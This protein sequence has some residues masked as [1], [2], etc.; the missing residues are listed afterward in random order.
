MSNIAITIRPALYHHLHPPFCTP[1]NSS[2]VASLYSLIRTRRKVPSAFFS[3]FFLDSPRRHYFV[4]FALVLDREHST[5]ASSTR[6]DQS[7][8][9]TDLCTQDL[10]SRPADASVDLR[11]GDNR[12]HGIRTG[13]SDVIPGTLARRP[14]PSLLP[15]T[16]ARAAALQ[17]GAVCGRRTT[18]AAGIGSHL[19]ALVD[20]VDAASQRLVPAAA[21]TLGVGVN[22]V[23]PH[24]VRLQVRWDAHSSYMYTGSGQRG[25][26]AANC[27]VARLRAS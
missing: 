13:S 22:R 16:Y 15:T 27:A 18:V 17:D 6:N 11:T 5:P 23:Q 1:N 12:H 2:P 10:T 4:T 7:I 25:N 26:G 14:P 19:A 3:Y 9:Q 8:C 24:T 21:R 20:L